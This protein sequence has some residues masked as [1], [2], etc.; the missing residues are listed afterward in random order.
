M[1]KILLT[2][3][4]LCLIVA[5]IFGLYSGVIGAK[6]ILKNLQTYKQAE[7]NSGLRSID[8]ELLPGIDQLS[9]NL[10]VYLDGVGQVADGRAQLADGYR[11]YNEGKAM[12][13]ANT[14]LYNKGKELEGTLNT[15]NGLI[16]QYRSTKE[17]IVNGTSDLLHNNPLDPLDLGGN[18]YDAAI[19]TAEQTFLSTV[20]SVLSTPLIT[21]T[22]G[23]SLDIP[24]DAESETELAGLA[25]K[26]FKRV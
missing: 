16:G 20:R 8:E 21:N 24:A 6:D 10:A 5:S 4:S 19:R 2:I 22:L 3:I 11:Q 23:M 14:D 9:E 1:K 17:A 18:T 7:A 15:V 13:A 25:E 12:L 26:K